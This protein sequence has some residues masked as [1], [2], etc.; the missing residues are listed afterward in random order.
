MGEDRPLPDA[1]S[2]HGYVQR[3]CFKTGPPGR[4]GAELEWLVAHPSDP[5]A[6][7]SLAYLSR[8]LAGAHPFPGGSRVTVEPGGQVELSSVPAGG[9]ARCHAALAR[10][11][12]HLQAVLGAAALALV[13]AGIDPSRLPVRQLHHARYD[14]M[15]AYFGTRPQGIGLVMMCST[16]AVQVN[17]DAGADPA[18]VA[19]RWDVLHR[20]GPALSAAFANSPRHNGRM[21]GWKSTRQAVWLHLDAGR[22]YAPAEGDPASAWTGY[23]LAAP[24]MML[25]TSQGPWLAS[26]G[27]SFG[28]WLDG[29]VPGLAPPTADDLR[30]H[31]TTLFPPVRPRGWFEVRYLDAQAAQWWPVPVAVLAT[32]LAS[33]RAADVAAEA[34]EP[35]AGAWDTA[36]R[37]GPGDPTLARAGLAVFEA[38][39]DLV[40]DPVVRQLVVRFMDRYIGRGRCPADDG[41][42][43]EQ[44]PDD[45]RMPVGVPDR[46]VPLALGQA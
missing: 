41:E 26:P 19:R 29:R 21:T 36:A 30:Y 46:T 4:V 22:P 42:A 45:D 40:P 34:C 35:T 44:G 23:A 31:L 15:A 24:V 32:L 33:P 17:L 6:V 3:I 27:F 7:V 38:I 39:A 1:E 2:V 11:V 13:P 9:L 37:H 18:D 16:A 10:D 25:R 14:A 28:E 43:V 12:A 20:V 8:V 5:G